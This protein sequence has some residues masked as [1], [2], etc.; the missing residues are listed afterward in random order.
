MSY[1]ITTSENIDKVPVIDKQILFSIDEGR[2]YA[3]L[4]NKE[5]GT[6]ER[7]IYGADTTELE[8]S[9]SELQQVA[10]RLAKI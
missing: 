6:V 7:K 4:Y 3:D 8:Q 10:D 1:G 5:T 9:V 2:L